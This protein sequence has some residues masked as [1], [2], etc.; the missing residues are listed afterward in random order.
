LDSK[1]QYL[2][3]TL[4]AGL[5]VVVARAS[6]QLSVIM[7]TFRSIGVH[8]ALRSRLVTQSSVIAAAAAAAAS[9][10]SESADAQALGTDP[11]TPPLLLSFSS[12]ETPLALLACHPESLRLLDPASGNCHAIDKEQ[13]TKLRQEVAEAIISETRDGLHVGR[14]VRHLSSPSLS[15]AAV[16]EDGAGQEPPGSAKRRKRS[17]SNVENESRSNALQGSDDNNDYLHDY[18][19]LGS[20]EEENASTSTKESRLFGTLTT[21]ELLQYESM[22]RG[23]H[24]GSPDPPEAA[25]LTTGCRQLDLLLSFPREYDAIV[26]AVSKRLCGG[27]VGW[28]EPQQ[29]HGTERSGGGGVPRGYVTQLFGPP[30]TGKTQVA[31]HVAAHRF[32]VSR[33]ACASATQNESEAE[34]STSRFP[35]WFLVSPAGQASCAERI[36]SLSGNDP[37]VMSQTYFHPVSNIYQVSSALGAV[38]E[39]LLSAAAPESKESSAE[40]AGTPGLVPPALI[41][42]DSASTCCCC[43][44]PNSDESQRLMS[45]LAKTLKRIARQHLAFV[46]VTNGTIKTTGPT[47]SAQGVDT[48]PSEARQTVMLPALGRIWERAVDVQVMVEEARASLPPNRAPTVRRA[49]LTRHPAKSVVSDSGSAPTTA[50]FAIH[51]TLG[52]RDATDQV[53]PA[54]S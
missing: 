19:H 21:L 32:R 53:G 37:A 7:P 10:S 28:H 24:Q 5:L 26:A 29:Q 22:L 36:A 16:E 27:G 43:S 1:F 20:N 49:T 8:P 9:S 47:S 30:A 54:R 42:L 51:P 35:C 17:N 18:Q 44:D 45:Q 48:A 12:V 52:I 2:S 41:V 13:V 6:K 3:T 46:I 31:L 14:V 15:F 50:F 11:A 23:Q 38:E 34:W 33:S 4:A 25:S 39:S 40:G